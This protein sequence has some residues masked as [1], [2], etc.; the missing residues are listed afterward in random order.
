MVDKNKLANKVEREL[1]GKNQVS[2][3]EE[4]AKVQ[5]VLDKKGLFYSGSL[6]KISKALKIVRIEH[7][8]EMCLIMGVCTTLY[9]S[10]NTKSD[11]LDEPNTKP[12]NK[13]VDIS[14][15]TN[16]Q[17]K[18]IIR[19]KTKNPKE[20][21]IKIKLNKNQ[22]QNNHQAPP[23]GFINPLK[24]KASFYRTYQAKTPKI[25]EK[26]NKLGEKKNLIVLQNKNNKKQGSVN[27]DSIEP[28]P[29][30]DLVFGLDFGSNLFLKKRSPDQVIHYNNLIRFFNLGFYVQ[31]KQYSKK[32]S[33]PYWIGAGVYFKNTH[34]KPLTYI[35]KYGGEQD[36]NQYTN[37]VYGL[38]Y[39]S[40]PID[41]LIL[42]KTKTNRLKLGFSLSP[43]IKV[44]HHGYTELIKE[45]MSSRV[46]SVS[47]ASGKVYDPDIGEIEPVTN[48][49][50]L[51]L[52]FLAEY[53]LRNKWSISVRL[54][55]GL[56]D[57]SNNK[58]LGKTKSFNRE[59]H[60][61][62]KRSLW[63]KTQKADDF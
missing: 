21:N 5:S 20:T 50:D 44:L 28:N 8:L 46:V 12:A 42:A 49:Y 59:M 29:T 41:V 3:T 39:I 60:L 51:G 37:H 26:S 35:Q 33:K 55:Q 61:S 4:W 15:K 32:Y 23:L 7:L 17:N 14:N 62:V 36:F 2:V 31:K 1:L 24:E 18:P 6:N 40:T 58:L 22:S 52:G 30:Q 16:I 9:Q 34:I 19:V 38:S 10:N 47:P 63:E 25:E 53:K 43:S 57:Y 27:G 56:L 54:Q 45:Q 11:Y 48:K 13:E